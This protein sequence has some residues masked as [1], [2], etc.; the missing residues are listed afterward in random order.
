MKKFLLGIL[1]LCTMLFGGCRADKDTDDIDGGVVHNETELDAPKIIESEEITNF[2]C[3]ISF[4]AMAFDEESELCGRVY[5]IGAVLNDDG[6]VYVKSKWRDRAGSSETNE[7]ESD[8]SFMKELQ[9]IVKKHDLAKHNG[10]VRRVSGLPDMYGAKLDV[11]YASGE[12]IYAYNNQDIL[13]PLEA[14]TELIELFSSEGK[15]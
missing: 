13:I 11:K 5:N 4:I 10:Y 7:Y 1:M 15:N 9:Q 14:A 2:E 8:I 12:S 6:V 3:E